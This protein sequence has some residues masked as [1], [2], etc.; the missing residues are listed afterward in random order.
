MGQRRWY[1]FGV[2]I[3]V[4]LL[5]VTGCKKIYTR[6]DMIEYAEQTLEDKYGEEFQVRGDVFN[7]RG[8]SYS[9]NVSPVNNP[10]II[11][12]VGYNIEGSVHN[13]DLYIESIVALQYKVLVEEQLGE[14]PCDYYLSA[15]L[16]LSDNDNPITDT[17]ISIE[18]YNKIINEKYQNPHY[19]LYFSRDIL[20]ESDEYIYDMLVS[21]IEA[22]EPKNPSLSVF[23]LREEDLE[24][25]KTELSERYELDGSTMSYIYAEYTG[26]V[27]DKE[28]GYVLFIGGT[29][30]EEKLSFEEFKK[31]NGGN[32][33]RCKMKMI[34][35]NIQH[36]QIRKYS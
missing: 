29:V 9:A 35:R 25:V 30:Q 20:V 11:F 36:I 12:E 14:I 7:V 24:L 33:G 3:L 32:K 16:Y 21:I 22:E 4:L 18:D 15:R 34:I 2:F 5:S 1:L 23:I 31:K 10:E 19:T 26:K 28:K 13:Y 6:K 17:E 27:A 8:S